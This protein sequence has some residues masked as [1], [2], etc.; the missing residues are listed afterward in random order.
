[1]TPNVAFGDAIDK[2]PFCFDPPYLK[3]YINRSV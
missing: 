2:A 3:D 1:L